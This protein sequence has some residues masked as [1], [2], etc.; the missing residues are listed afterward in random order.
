MGKS[1]RPIEEKKPIELLPV[2]D[3]NRQ[4]SRP[5]TGAIDLDNG[6][7]DTEY[8]KKMSFRQ[9]RQSALT[10]AASSLGQM[11][12]TL[13]G[14]TIQGIDAVTFGAIDSL[15]NAAQGK[16]VDFSTGL[17]ELGRDIEDWGREKMPIWYDDKAGFGSLNY[18]LGNLPSVVSTVSMLLPGM[19]AAAVFGKVGKALRMSQL[20]TS[21]MEVGGG[22]LVGRH[23]ENTMEA[24]RVFKTK[25]DEALEMGLD[26]A[27]ARKNASEAATLD[28]QMNYANLAFDVLQLGAIIKPSMFKL[29]VGKAGSKIERFSSM[30]YEA[31][32]AQALSKTGKGLLNGATWY[33]K[34]LI[35]SG[36]YAAMPLGQ[37][38]EGVEEFWNTVSQKESERKG[39]MENLEAS[40]LKETDPYRYQKEME[41]L[42]PD[43]DF[44]TRLKGYAKD[45]DAKESA[46]WGWIGGMAYNAV[47]SG[48]QAFKNKG[49]TDAYGS[50]RVADFA[51]R[52]EFLTNNLKSLNDPKLSESERFK[53][54]HDSI[55][56]LAE[57]AMRSGNLETLMEDLDDEGY[58]KFIAKQS[59][60]DEETAKKQIADLK[61][62]V[63]S[64]ADDY[65]KFTGTTLAGHKA[66]NDYINTAPYGDMTGFNFDVGDKIPES[67]NGYTPKYLT[68]TVK[69]GQYV[70]LD[71]SKADTEAE[72][73]DGYVIAK[74]RDGKL[75]VGEQDVSELGIP[76]IDAR[77]ALPVKDVKSL[78]IKRQGLFS[79]VN[80]DIGITMAQLAYYSRKAE[81][82]GT[83]SAIAAQMRIAEEFK[84][85]NPLVRNYADMRMKM[86]VSDKREK[87]VKS[88]LAIAKKTGVSSLMTDDL[89]TELKDLQTRKAA[90]TQQADGLFKLI[91]E[92]YNE[93]TLGNDGTL[94]TVEDQLRAMSNDQELFEMYWDM[95]DAN[96]TKRHAAV[97]R[98]RF[99]KD[100]MGY[101]KSYNED[102]D[103]I[104]TYEE[105]IK[106]DRERYGIEE[107]DPENIQLQKRAVVDTFDDNI[108]ESDSRYIAG[109]RKLYESEKAKHAENY[110]V[111]KTAAA[112]RLIEL[113]KQLAEAIK[114]VG[115][116][117]FDTNAY[118][119]LKAEADAITGLKSE[120]P[121]KKEVPTT[122][123]NTTKPVLSD[124][125]LSDVQTA[126][127]IQGFV[128]TINEYYDKPRPET[129]T[130]VTA[131]GQ[132]Y[133]TIINP[134]KQL[135]RVQELLQK[136]KSN[137]PLTED[138]DFELAALIDEKTGSGIIAN[139]IERSYYNPVNFTSLATFSLIPK[140]ANS[141]LSA[142][143]QELISKFNDIV[144]KLALEQGPIDGYS[145]SNGENSKDVKA[146]DLHKYDP[147]DIITRL[148][149]PQV[150]SLIQGEPVFDFSRFVKETLPKAIAEFNEE[151]IKYQQE[152]P[153]TKETV[154]PSI[155]QATAEEVK[156]GLASS[157]EPEPVSGAEGEAL[158]VQAS[159]PLTFKDGDPDFNDKHLGTSEND[160]F[161]VI[162]KGGLLSKE[163]D[164]NGKPLLSID[165]GSGFYDL[166]LMNPESKEALKAGD[167]VEVVHEPTLDKLDNFRVYKIAKNGSR[168]PMGAIA[169]S[170]KNDKAIAA[171]ARFKAMMYDTEDAAKKADIRKRREEELEIHK[172]STPKTIGAINAKYDA[173]L[174]AIKTKGPVSKRFTIANNG[175]GFGY[176]IQSQSVGT[177]RNSAKKKLKLSQITSIDKINTKDTDAMHLAVSD[178]QIVGVRDRGGSLRNLVPNGGVVVGSNIGNNHSGQTIAIVPTNTI[179]SN[180]IRPELKGKQA[181]IQLLMHTAPLSNIRI[182]GETMPVR[183]M[184]KLLDPLGNEV[185]I[186]QAA[187]MLRYK[188]PTSQLKMEDLDGFYTESN[189]VALF[190]EIMFIKGAL[191][192]ENAVGQKD[193]TYPIHVDVFTDPKGVKKLVISNLSATGKKE[194]YFDIGI[195][196]MNEVNASILR[197]FE[198][199]FI[200]NPGAGV[201]KPF[202]IDASQIGTNA[203]SGPYT[204]FGVADNE[205]VIKT[206]PSYLH[207][208]DENSILTG[209]FASVDLP[210]QNRKTFFQKP[211]VKINFEKEASSIQM[212]TKPNTNAVPVPTVKPVGEN[213][214]ADIERLENDVMKRAVLKPDQSAYTVNGI[215][216][217]RV[218]TVM[219]KQFESTDLTDKA[220]EFGNVV[221]TAIRDAFNGGL[222]GRTAY[223]ALS[224]F[225]AKFEAGLEVFT[226]YLE[227]KGERVISGRN[228]IYGQ[229]KN[230]N[231]DLVDTA[232]EM[233]IVTIDASN[234]IRIYDTKTLRGQVKDAGEERVKDWKKQLNYYKDLFN[235][236]G[237]DIAGIYILPI[238]ISYGKENTEIVGIDFPG[239]IMQLEMTEGNVSD[240]NRI[241]TELRTVKN[242][243]E[244]AKAEPN[245]DL[246]L[247]VE[248]KKNRLKGKNKSNNKLTSILKIDQDSNIYD[249]MMDASLDPA[250]RANLQELAKN[251]ILH[252]LYQESIIKRRGNLN[253]EKSLLPKAKALIEAR[254]QQYYKIADTLDDKGR[255]LVSDYIAYNE[256][257][258]ERFDKGTF[259]AETKTEV[260]PFI[261]YFRSAYIEVS[262]SKIVQNR[263]QEDDNINLDEEN[264]TV[265]EQEVNRLRN[266][267]DEAYTT[268]NP[269]STVAFQAK[270]FLSRIPMRTESGEILVNDAGA[271][272][273]Y[274]LD[275]TLNKM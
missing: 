113:N 257:L 259:T 163:F 58:I 176:L 53:A 150:S 127:S 10:A 270:L 261:G 147:D 129:A 30:G 149:L 21:L 117:G 248:A 205:L 224:K 132:I 226:N 74:K 15:V 61:A 169:E 164:K 246:K 95:Y 174:A 207:Y 22:A 123:L 236:Q 249:A 93:P 32:N 4:F 200:S 171:E 256:L 166:A 77:I 144:S 133:S 230:E 116:E 72:T 194:L 73:T 108:K 221:D 269:K 184:R 31:A 142:L 167:V 104:S 40:G 17:G 153:E 62:D 88:K 12:T 19:G 233:D 188:L 97:Q 159:V 75:M 112:G 141:K 46:L 45:K 275:D 263:I 124:T 131:L 98:Q 193:Y 128:D 225:R 84:N 183:L 218:H 13:V 217:Q 18:I 209:T 100:P 240:R 9:S 182:Q 5:I 28:Y 110:N 201:D 251:A 237:Y 109:N 94:A 14:Q 35:Q 244:E 118:I 238:G 232:G 148:K 160:G 82:Q 253:V 23:V 199:T 78:E 152:N 186:R 168:I 210:G 69:E 136:Q 172:L 203:K 239:T 67:E 175:I 138:E 255:A 154:I 16:P 190:G 231:G 223:P 139:N 120:V 245:A 125:P 252:V 274:N 271:E 43:S 216:Y 6:L 54:K 229:V 63:K 213:P 59:G 161:V 145:Y 71:L 105:K 250:V 222:K 173:E 8:E 180:T 178:G 102:S 115:E 187:A 36:R 258:L 170:T 91:T 29:G 264:Q 179:Y 242:E 85:T 48:Y 267:G 101:Y 165:N 273:F 114:K 241:I 56:G 3:A 50:A 185:F 212:E 262:S 247:E 126:S 143:N 135:S 107:T 197:E 76:I 39:T 254:L 66:Y 65:D 80:P 206:Y 2:P 202:R 34:S 181:Y 137:I 227:A 96:L 158:F 162:Y 37:M 215:D 86:V 64:I 49:K 81:Q 47:G 214:N 52:N 68:D 146:E 25:Y 196:Q 119:K 24:S 208:L 156:R 111:N 90:L 204:G 198:Q 228:T 211:P 122:N 33:E 151:F 121:G 189:M 20:A 140:L 99:L 92:D 195:S 220:V 7:S 51:R 235:Y 83:K 87:T 26:D 177:S 55:F 44:M 155:V 268:I 38:T 266:F 79:F 41:A 191:K 27:T 243:K 134:S 42:N 157:A 1:T 57:S 234:K 106:V 272:Q 11:T 89:E 192:S 70:R 60:I 130:D 219:G 260:G 265:D 103:K